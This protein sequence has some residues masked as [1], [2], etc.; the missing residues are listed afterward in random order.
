MGSRSRA[1]GAPQTPPNARS[2]DSVSAPSPASD[3]R[4]VG[5]L[6]RA[7]HQLNLGEIDA[8]TMALH[9]DLRTR[10]R[11]FVRRKLEEFRNSLP[12][13]FRSHPQISQQLQVLQRI[14]LAAE[15]DSLTEFLHGVCGIFEDYFTRV[16][17]P[18]GSQDLKDIWFNG[19]EPRWNQQVQVLKANLKRQYH[20]ESPQKVDALARELENGAAHIHDHQL[21]LW[22][23][24]IQKAASLETFGEQGR[25][26]ALPQ[27]EG[28]KEDRIA[29]AILGRIRK[30]AYLRPY[31]E[32]WKWLK[33]GNTP[34]DFIRERGEYL[35]SWY[36]S[37]NYAFKMFNKIKGW[38]RKRILPLHPKS[39][40]DSKNSL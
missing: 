19:I 28:E 26:A 9:G 33:A 37:D 7:W 29:K 24:K 21:R 1:K 40:R 31:V 30:S 16:R 15:L 36:I 32:M 12:P 6:R 4:P 23:V 35:R 10:K 5:K 3:G 17:I 14:R 27:A 11:D 22:M 2:E 25:V 38:Q 20:T 13:E 8:R 39:G 18:L 34:A